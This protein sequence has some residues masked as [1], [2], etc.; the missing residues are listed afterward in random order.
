MA[1]IVSQTNAG[2][3]LMRSF[4]LE[5]RARPSIDLCTYVRGA[6]QYKRDMM[7]PNAWLLLL[8]FVLGSFERSVFLKHDLI[9]PMRVQLRLLYLHTSILNSCKII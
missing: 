2:I 3:S 5:R 6:T 9:V 1:L 7:W 8:S 4:A